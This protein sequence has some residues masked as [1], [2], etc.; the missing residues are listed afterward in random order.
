LL[1]R[2]R[3]LVTE[4]PGTT[5]DAIEA[6][7]DFLGWPVRLVDTAG[8]GESQ[9][10]IDELGQ[11]M[12]RRYLESADLVLMC[13]DESRGRRLSDSARLPPLPTGRVLQVGTKADLCDGAREGL[14]VSAVSGEGLGRLRQVVAERLFQGGSALA[15]LEPALTRDRHRVA[16]ANAARALSDAAPHLVVGGDAVLAAHHV[17][18]AVRALDTLV[19]VVDIEEVLDRVFASFCVGK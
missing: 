8:L 19:G 3:A 14:R 16:L 11:A 12:S 17:Q 4:L 15:D 9:D 7:A 2:D 13:E 10:R 18:E 5:R 6:H 1:G